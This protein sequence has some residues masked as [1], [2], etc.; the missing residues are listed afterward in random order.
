MYAVAAQTSTFM[1]ISKHIRVKRDFRDF[2]NGGA[3]FRI[4]TTDHIGN[5]DPDASPIGQKCDTPTVPS[6]VSR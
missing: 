5:D 2:A 6:T 4:R 1:P 3:S